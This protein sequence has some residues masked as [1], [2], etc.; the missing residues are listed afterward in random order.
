MAAIGYYLSVR[1]LMFEASEVTACR[2]AP[3]VRDVPAFGEAQGMAELMRM[4]I[5]DSALRFPGEPIG[6]RMV[7]AELSRSSANLHVAPLD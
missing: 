3:P 7:L 4:Q 5:A 2:I 6:G 1:D